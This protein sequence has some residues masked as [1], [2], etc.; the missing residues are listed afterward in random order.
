MKETMKLRA[1][2][3]NGVRDWECV[4]GETQLLEGFWPCNEKG[5]PGSLT[6]CAM[7]Q[8]EVCGC[9][10]IFNCHT[11][12]VMGKR[13]DKKP[14]SIAPDFTDYEYPLDGG[15]KLPTYK[16]YVVDMQLWE[17]RKIDKPWESLSLDF[18]EGDALFAE[19]LK[20]LPK[21]HIL[22]EEFWEGYLRRH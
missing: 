8:L 14:I 3:D 5:E 7:H 9:G 10:R 16:G 4:C 15:R 13:G 17:F 22:R 19:L 18:Q 2:L 1:K 21:E 6:P 12:E 20:R 11:G